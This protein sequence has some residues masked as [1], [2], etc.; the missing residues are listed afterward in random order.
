MSKNKMAGR[1]TLYDHMM[2]GLAL[3]IF[4]GIGYIVTVLVDDNNFNM[5]LI[6][7]YK[8]IIF[9]GWLNTILIAVISV[10]LSFIL[11]FITY[12]ILNINK[13]SLVVFKYMAEIY[14]NVMF[15]TPLVVALLV[16]YYYIGTAINYDN[17]F[18]LGFI[19]LSLYMSPYMT[20]LF[21]GAMESI[22]KD[23]HIASDIFGFTTIQK[24]RYIIFPQLLK[25]IVPPLTGNL[26]FVIKGSGLLYFIGYQELFYAIR[27]A[28]SRTFAFSE[29]YM[30]LWAMYLIVTL[31]L[32]QLTKYTEK[33][34]S[35][36]GY[37]PFEDTVKET[38]G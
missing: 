16:F 10:V 8:T 20:N 12:L 36:N 30:L 25:I 29:G 31:P 3:L 35:T 15:G 9:K 17:R 37:I 38:Q 26:T 4:V 23:Q 34:L 33:R 14:N 11:G 28:Q 22:G 1:K 5:Q 21:I 18:V 7:D 2:Y 13:R 6:F 32:I 24:Y 19:S 27:I